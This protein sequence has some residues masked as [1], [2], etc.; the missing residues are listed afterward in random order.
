MPDFTVTI[1]AVEAGVLSSFFPTAQEGIEQAT[2]RLVRMYAK[3][4]IYNSS[5]NLDPRKM[6]DSELRDELL[7]IQDEV[8]TY[9]ER[10]PDDPI[11]S[12]STSVI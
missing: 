6:S 9:C 1:T 2:R 5:S 4:I 8:P 3:N 12:D 10:Y 7:V 11:C